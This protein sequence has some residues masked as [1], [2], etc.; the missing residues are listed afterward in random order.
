MFLAAFIALYSIAGSVL[1]FLKG[2]FLY[3]TYP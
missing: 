3:F 2:P 1:L